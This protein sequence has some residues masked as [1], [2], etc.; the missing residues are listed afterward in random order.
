M[1][2]IGG[3]EQ[4]L[5][6]MDNLNSDSYELFLFLNEETLNY[7]KKNRLSGEDTINALYTIYVAALISGLSHYKDKLN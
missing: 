1:S 5:Q 6:L 7:V 3:R 4:V 2:K